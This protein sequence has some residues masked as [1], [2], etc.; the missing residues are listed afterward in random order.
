MGFYEMKQPQ[1]NQ[2][3]LSQQQWPE[4]TVPWVSILC[5]TYNHANFIRDAIEGFLMQE[6]TFPV[7]ILVHDDASS[8][9]TAQIVLSYEQKY[10]QLITGIYQKTN[11]YSQKVS[12]TKFFQPHIKGR[13]LAFCEGD[14]YWRDVNK[15][16]IQIGY[17]ESH[18]DCA[19]S[20][21]DAIVVDEYGEIIKTSVVRRKKKDFLPEGVLRGQAILPTASRVFRTKDSR[22]LFART[23]NCFQG[24][25]RFILV[26]LGLC[27]GSHYHHDIQPSAYRMH[28]GGV[29]SSLP[30][31][32]KYEVSS[33]TSYFLYEY[34]RNIGR[35]DVS[36][37]WRMRWIRTTARVMPIM[38]LLN[39]IVGNIF[40]RLTA[41]AKRL[42]G[43]KNLESLHQ[44]I[45]KF[46][47][48]GIKRE[49]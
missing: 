5:I 14:D 48:P 35:K 42:L 10:P 44:L 32:Q 25:D 27:G 49:W 43:R 46:I 2:V 24:G 16:E 47:V 9:G 36:D 22:P 1:G 7:E 18:P 33:I 37:Y 41:F 8:D 4:G 26:T 3:P 45:E 13:Y 6:T 28:E 31:V 15:L 11:Q 30:Q 12:P 34:F 19:I 23:Y 39:A 38:V 40:H 17:L 21:H 29:H 20:G